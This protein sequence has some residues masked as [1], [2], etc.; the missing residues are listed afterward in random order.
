MGIEEF[1]DATLSFEKIMP[2][3]ADLPWD[4]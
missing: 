1:F 2:P 4:E 3:L